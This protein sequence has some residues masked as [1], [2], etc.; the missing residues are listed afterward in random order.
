MLRIVQ[1]IC[2]SLLCLPQAGCANAGGTARPPAPVRMSASIAARVTSG[3]SPL[4]HVEVQSVATPASSVSALELLQENMLDVGIAMA[5]VTYLAYNGQLD[6]T[7]RAFDQLRGMA[8]LNLNTLHLVAGRDTPI[9][10]VGDL[11]GRRVALG[12]QGS[13]TARIAQLLLTASGLNGTAVQSVRLPYAETVI[14]LARGDLDAAFMTQPVDPPDLAVKTATEQGA[15][16][17]TVDGAAIDTLRVEYPFL[18]RA[19]IPARTY[20][21]QREAVRT[22]GVDLVLVCRADLDEDHVYRM[23]QAYFAAAA[24][25]MSPGDL[26]RAP[27][28]PIP[29]HAGAARYYRQRELSR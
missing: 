10:S 23:M 16:L 25:A 6:G 19:M 17:L 3:P 12:P 7:D 18:K 13:A 15:R 1:A 8:L 24:G 20:P 9:H 2:L 11:R 22:I 14:R 4:A 21:G 26:D 5:D 28:T 29:L 27:A